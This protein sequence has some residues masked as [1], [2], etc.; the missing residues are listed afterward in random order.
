MDGNAFKD[1]KEPNA[2]LVPYL[3]YLDLAVN[4]TVE[5]YLSPDILRKYPIPANM[6]PNIADVYEDSSAILWYSND[7]LYSHNSD[8]VDNTL[9]A[10]N[11]TTE[12][13]SFVEVS[14]NNV[15]LVDRSSE[16]SASIESSGLAFSF[17]STGK[18][19]LLKF[20]NLVPQSL[21]WSNETSRLGGI[22]VPL[23]SEAEMVYVP[24]GKEG[25]LLIIGGMDVSFSL[26]PGRLSKLT[27]SVAFAPS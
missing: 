6:T 4:L 24:M 21:T 23:V 26:L 22:Q 25:V 27:T 7:T 1:L 15:Q 17:G 18:P 8:R 20:N 11:T 9:A 3:F 19:G 2:S 16:M 5:Q 13:W 10:F 14:G 12:N